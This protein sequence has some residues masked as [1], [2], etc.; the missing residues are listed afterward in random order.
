MNIYRKNVTSFNFLYLP[1]TSSRDFNWMKITSN[2]VTLKI[3]FTSYG[4]DESN[5]KQFKKI[6]HIKF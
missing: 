6:F 3:V 1:L 4:G 5:E 2:T